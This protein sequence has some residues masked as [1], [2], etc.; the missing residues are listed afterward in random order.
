[1]VYLMIVSITQ[2][3]WHKFMNEQ[4]ILRNVEVAVTILELTVIQQNHNNC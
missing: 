2:A 4:W 3:K 1:M